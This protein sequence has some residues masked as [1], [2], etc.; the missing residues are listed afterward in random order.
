MHEP[1]F[2][3][4]VLVVFQQFNL[5]PRTSALENVSAAGVCRRCHPERRPRAR[6]TAAGGPGERGDHPRRTVRPG[7]SSVAIARAL[8][9]QPQL[10]LADDLPAPWMPPPAEDIM[11][12]LSR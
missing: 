7:S 8:V 12:L 3:T 2:A 11:Q 5:L 1:P 6:H 10:I 9:N 4:G